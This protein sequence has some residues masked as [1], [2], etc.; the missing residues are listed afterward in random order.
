MA[1]AWTPV[2]LSY[3]LPQGSPSQIGRAWEQCPLIFP[4]LISKN[5]L[6]YHHG[7]VW[8]SHG[9]CDVRCQRTVRLSQFQHDLVLGSG[10][11]PPWSCSECPFEIIRL[12]SR[13]DCGWKMK[14]WVQLVFGLPNLFLEV[15]WSILSF[16]Y[17]N[18]TLTIWPRAWASSTELSL[19]VMCSGWACFSNKRS[20]QHSLYMLILRGRC[21]ETF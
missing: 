9:V 16:T 18:K 15:V 7:R 20:H 5:I 2:S 14:G 19:L 10:T 3:R 6:G 13:F 21:Q 8:V 12:C 17:S 4:E 1:E 11:Q